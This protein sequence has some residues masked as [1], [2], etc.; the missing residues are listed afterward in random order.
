MQA[1]KAAPCGAAFVCSVF[2]KNAKIPRMCGGFLY[3]YSSFIGVE[4]AVA[5]ELKFTATSSERFMKQRM[6]A[7]FRH[8]AF[9]NKARAIIALLIV[10]VMDPIKEAVAFHPFPRRGV[11]RTCKKAPFERTAAGAVKHAGEFVF[12]KIEGNAIHFVKHVR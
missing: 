11:I 2:I 8:R 5:F 6:K 10:H 12:F 3:R 1:F 4:F 9:I 7:I